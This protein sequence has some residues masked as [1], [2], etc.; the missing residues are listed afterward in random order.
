MKY[1]S[2]KH[3]RDSKT[4]FFITRNPFNESDSISGSD[5][6]FAHP[7]M[8]L[9]PSVYSSWDE[10]FA[11]DKRTIDRFNITQHDLLGQLD[12]TSFITL[13]LDSLAIHFMHNR[14]IKGTEYDTLEYIESEYGT[15]DHINVVIMAEDAG[16]LNIAKQFV[17]VFRDKKGECLSPY[18]G[19]FYED[20]LMSLPS[21]FKYIVNPI[22][23]FGTQLGL[24]GIMDDV[25]NLIA[26]HQENQA[27]VFWNGV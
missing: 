5:V 21:S 8:D 17:H 16:V 27:P 15:G 26:D 7:G 20:E 23:Y 22:F 4:V 12:D 14:L 3:F 9:I 10:C 11:L 25:L 13:K 24:V 19:S 18:K 1:L 6:K 2:K